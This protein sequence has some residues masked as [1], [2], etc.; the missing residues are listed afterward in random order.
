MEPRGPRHFGWDA[1][2]LP[3]GHEQTYAEMDAALKNT[4]SHRARAIEK[5]REFAVRNAAAIRAALRRAK[6]VP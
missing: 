5:L 6:S 4:L 3:D 2:F 1:V